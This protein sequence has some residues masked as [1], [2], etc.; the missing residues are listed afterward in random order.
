MQLL[1]H[2]V[3]DMLDYS[4]IKNQKYEKKM[5]KFDPNVS[6]KDTM[7]MFTEQ[8]R[9]KNIT[10]EHRVSSFL[11]PP[12]PSGLRVDPFTERAY[13]DSMQ[14]MPLLKAAE[15]DERRLPC[16]KGDEVRL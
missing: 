11:D 10:L 15:Q 5:S 6:I 13:D 4:Q 14:Q 7:D 1:L 12:S 3:N 9:A 2:F 16:L 8:V